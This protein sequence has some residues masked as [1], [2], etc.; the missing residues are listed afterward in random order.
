M[1]LIVEIFR[2]SARSRDDE[3]LNAFKGVNAVTLINV[4]GPFPPA[5]DAPAA[6]LETNALGNPIIVP[7]ERPENTAGPMFGGTYGATSDSRFGEAIRAI[8][9]QYVY[10][11]L[12]VHDRFESWE[13]Y[14][15]LSR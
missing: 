7:V 10:G 9:R 14:D 15:R 1:G 12:P 3:Q 11:A 4:E 5:P 6:L 13:L 8:S 2:N